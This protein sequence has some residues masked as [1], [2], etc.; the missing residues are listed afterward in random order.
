MESMKPI[1]SFASSNSSPGSVPSGSSKLTL[2]SSPKSV[3]IGCSGSLSTALVWW[4]S[5]VDGD[6]AAYMSSDVEPLAERK[7][8]NSSSARK[9]DDGE[10]TAFVVQGRH[11]TVTVGV[12]SDFSRSARVMNAKSFALVSFRYGAKKLSALSTCSRSFLNKR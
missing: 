2:D 1:V 12:E 10:R 8:A 6:A 3:P 9:M 4:K 5:A 7:W 11:D